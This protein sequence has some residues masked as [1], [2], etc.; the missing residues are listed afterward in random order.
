MSVIAP[1][2]P[3]RLV[4]PKDGSDQLTSWETATI[5]Y[6]GVRFYANPDGDP[7]FGA[8]VVDYDAV[9]DTGGP[10]DAEYTGDLW[11]QAGDHPLAEADLVPEGA[12]FDP[13][14]TP[15]KRPAVKPLMWLALQGG[16]YGDSQALFATEDAA[17]AHLAEHARNDWHELEGW[18][19]REYRAHRGKIEQLR[20]VPDEPPADDR[21]AATLYFRHHLNAWA[22]VK[23]IE[24]QG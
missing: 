5:P 7:N 22:D 10:D 20:T 23:S 21:E 8:V 19:N 18:A 11:C 9:Y 16:H 17:W 6:Y 15:P 14:W 4:C 12:G 3:T 2:T 13:D 24:V 1:A